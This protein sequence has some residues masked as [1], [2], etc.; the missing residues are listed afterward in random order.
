MFRVGGTFGRGLGRLWFGLV[1][2]VGDSEFQAVGLVVPGMWLFRA[3]AGG[4]VF[5]SQAAV[6]QCNV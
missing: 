2:E 5:R 1:W 4:E 3:V 6:F